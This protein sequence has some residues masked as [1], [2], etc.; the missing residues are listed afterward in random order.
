L[1]A[2]LV[3]GVPTVTTPGPFVDDDLAGAVELAAGP[4]EAWAALD[5]LLAD[6]SRRETV[7]DA[8]RTYGRA[9]DWATIAERHLATYERLL[10]RG[11]VP[12]GRGAGGPADVV[13]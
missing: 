4:D 1:L 2:L 9:R 8:A 11:R 10:E 5:R 6:E 13:G 7:G 12:A 3:N